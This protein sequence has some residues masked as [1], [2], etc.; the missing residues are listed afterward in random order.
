MLGLAA[1]VVVLFPVI[2][3][4]D[5]TPGWTGLAFLLPCTM[6]A[7]G[8]FMKNAWP[9]GRSPLQV[10]TGFLIV[11]TALLTPV[12][13]LTAAEPLEQ[14]GGHVQSIPLLLLSVTIG[15]EFFLFS[16]LIRSGGAVV[17]SC[18]DYVAVLAGLGWGFVMF[19]ER[20]NP[21]IWMAVGLGFLAL[22]LICRPHQPGN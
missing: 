5:N 15:V 4:A 22:W 19:G 9:A 20:P 14:L 12:H 10:S 1:A 7:C 21:G 3:F 2:S 16:L 11:G 13:F 17:A 8:V 18:A 6:A